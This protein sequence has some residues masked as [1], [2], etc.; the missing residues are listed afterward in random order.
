MNQFIYKALND[1]ELTDGEFRLY[2]LIKELGNNNDGY[3]YAT[4]SYFAKIIGK[5]EKSISR[6]IGILIKKGYLYMITLTKGSMTEE[7]RLYVEES[8]KTYLEDSEN[9]KNKK[10]IRTYFLKEKDGEGTEIIITVNERNHK[11]YTG[12]KNATGNNNVTGTGNN[13]EDGTGNNIVTQIYNNINN[14]NINNKK[15]LSNDNIQKDEI[16]ETIK[17]FHVSDETKEMFRNFREHRKKKNKTLKDS[18][19][20]KKLVREL[21]TGKFKDEKHLRESIQESIDFG[22]QGVFP[23]KNYDFEP[24]FKSKSIENT[25]SMRRLA[26]IGRRKSSGNIDGNSE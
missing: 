4:N 26:E 3:C 10:T 20:F 7:R 19:V 22:Y 6:L 2:M 23:V 24:K 16:E 12:N 25:D 1:K 5:H 13:F 15:I 11:E 8:Y 14:N 21:G 18:G 9:K 17:S